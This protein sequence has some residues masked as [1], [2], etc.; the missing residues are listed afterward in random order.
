MPIPAKRQSGVKPMVIDLD[1]REPNPSHDVFMKHTPKDKPV[2][3]FWA[4]PELI[5]GEGS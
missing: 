4:L 2:R 5:W 1:Y 3:N